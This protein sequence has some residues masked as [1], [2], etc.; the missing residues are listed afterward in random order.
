MSR[1]AGE[2]AGRLGTGGGGIGINGIIIHLLTGFNFGGG[3]QG[4]QEAPRPIARKATEGEVRPCGAW[5]TEEVWGV[6]LPKH[7]CRYREPKL[8]LLRTSVGMRARRCRR[9]AILLPR[10]QRGLCRP[11]SRSSP[12]WNGE[13]DAPLASSPAPM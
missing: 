5:H 13:V 9:R 12:R 6:E 1:I 4:V 8:V 7:R 2:W 3:G 11:T 10:R